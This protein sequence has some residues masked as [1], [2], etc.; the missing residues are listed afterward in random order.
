[1]GSIIPYIQKITS[2]FFFAHLDLRLFDSW[3][4]FQT[5]IPQKN[6]GE[7]WWLDHGRK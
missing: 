3:K 6:G 2:Y 5:I 7:K 1:M 4:K